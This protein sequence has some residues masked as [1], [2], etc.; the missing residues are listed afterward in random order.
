MFE[1]GFDAS[2]KT[3]GAQAT[4]QFMSKRG[5]KYTFTRAASVSCAVNR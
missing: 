2:V 3:E 5:G 1:K 4:R